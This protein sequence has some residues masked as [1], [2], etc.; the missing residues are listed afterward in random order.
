M[1]S[2]SLHTDI[3]GEFQTMNIEVA[4]KIAREFGMSDDEIAKAVKELE[5]VEHRLQAHKSW[6]KT[7]LGRWL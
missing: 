6:W 1:D 7:H 2:L 3:L 4:V 5:P